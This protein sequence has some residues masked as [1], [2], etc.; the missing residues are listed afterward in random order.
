MKGDM[1]DVP[2]TGIVLD[3]S[4]PPPLPTGSVMNDGWTHAVT[5]NIMATGHGS[6]LLRLLRENNKFNA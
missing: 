2:I 3:A 5:E 1:M 6:L 4:L